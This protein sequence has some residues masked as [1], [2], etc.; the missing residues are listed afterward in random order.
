MKQKTCSVKKPLIWILWGLLILLI[1]V[2]IWASSTGKLNLLSSKLSFMKTQTSI[3]SGDQIVVDYIG[4]HLDGKVFDTS[5]QS[6]AQEAGLY[7]PQRNYEEGLAFTVG[8]GQMIKG[9]D[10]AVIG[11]TVGETKTVEIPADKAY[12]ER[13]E[14]M[15]IRVPLQEAGDLSGAWVGM[16]IL[17]GGMYP[18]TITEITDTEIVFDANHELAGK[19]L[20]FDITI[21][22]I[23]SQ[24]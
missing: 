24:K 20:V 15:V 12:G 13:S 8:A 22:S 7:N 11:M 19:A 17:L 23:Q 16:K 3:Q 6:V 5:I 18:A 10:E 4:K 14:E 1:G 9:F 21:K 2:G